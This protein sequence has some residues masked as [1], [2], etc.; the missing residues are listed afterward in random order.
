MHRYSIAAAVVPLLLSHAVAAPVPAEKPIGNDLP[1]PA[2]AL[3]VVQLNGVERVRGRLETMLK[4]AAPDVAEAASKQFDDA[5]SSALNGR[6]IKA[7]SPDAR[8]FVVVTGFDLNAA[9]PPVAVLVPVRDLATFKE[10][11]LTG[12]ERKSWEK[13]DDGVFSF[14]VQDR[15]M[16]VAEVPGAG[17]V[18]VARDK[19]AVGPFAGK[20]TRLTPGQMGD[21]TADGFLSSDLSVYVNLEQINEDFGDK[22]RQG[23]QLLQLLMQQGAAMG[24]AVDKRQLD[25]AKVVFDAMFQSVEDGRGAVLGLTFR[26]E[27]LALRADALFSSDSSTAKGLAQEQPA[28]L[29]LLADMPGGLTTFVGGKIGQKLALAMNQFGPEF[30]AEDEEDKIANVFNK[31]NELEAAAQAGGFA[32]AAD[33]PGLVLNV[34]TPADP[35]AWVEAKRKAFSGLTGGAWYRNVVVKDKPK[36]VEEAKKVGGFTLHEVKLALDFEA[37]VKNIP[38]ANIRDTTIASMKRMAM[39][40]PTVWFGTDGKRV[41]QLTA[42]DWPAAEKVL[43]RYLEGKEKVGGDAAFKTTRGQLPEETSVVAMTEINRLAVTLSES[44]A[45]LSETIPGL[46]IGKLPKLKPSAVGNVYLGI[47]IGMKPAAFRFDLFL[48][49]ESVKAVREMVK[50]VLEKNKE[51]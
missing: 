30:R 12:D 7:L 48:P 4:T 40:K 43:T 22:I 23:R 15:A 20:F 24:G 41:I 46:P 27:G 33:T 47:A 21:A 28:T 45:D 50:P 29:P 31:A 11:L 25:M 38:D 37:T 35:A 26:P 13:H 19:A 5:L 44:F 39:E 18:A 42:G 9:E 10:K 1:I 32:A 49:A 51:D 17:Y 3:V 14:D 34:A 16:Y 36:V 8:V 6:D 2:T